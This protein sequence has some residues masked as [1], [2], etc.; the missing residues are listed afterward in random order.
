M[1]SVEAQILTDLPVNWFKSGL[2]CL[3]KGPWFWSLNQGLHEMI[4]GKNG[5]RGSFK[6]LIGD[7]TGLGFLNILTSAQ[8]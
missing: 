1:Y 6:T 2:A 7:E 5:S 8:P 4:F 3:T